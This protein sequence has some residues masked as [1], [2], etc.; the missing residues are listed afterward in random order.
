MTFLRDCYGTGAD[1][2][3]TAVL[4]KNQYKI[5][6]WLYENPTL[7][8]EEISTIRIQEKYVK[9]QKYFLDAKKSSFFFN[10]GI[11]GFQ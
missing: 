7:V 6:F 3:S 4:A 9:N 10:F 11:S 8:F 2:L 5:Q 1:I